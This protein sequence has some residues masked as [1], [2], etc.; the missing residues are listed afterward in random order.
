M[1]LIKKKKVLRTREILSKKPLH[2]K[3]ALSLLVNDCGFSYLCTIDSHIPISTSTSFTGLQ[4][5]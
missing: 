5:Q 2:L 1:M 4:L 3:M